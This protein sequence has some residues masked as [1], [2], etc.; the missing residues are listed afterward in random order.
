MPR[1]YES[2]GAAVD[3]GDDLSIPV[4]YCRYCYGG[5]KQIAL[6][7]NE[8]DGDEHEVDQDH[9]PYDETDYECETCN[10]K[11]TERDD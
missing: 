11:L 10:R 1:I 7:Q 6:Q 3:S 8:Q 4:D 2:T 9:P 5:A